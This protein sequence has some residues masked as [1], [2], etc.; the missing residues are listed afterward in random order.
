MFLLVYMTQIIKLTYFV[1]K[2]NNK[3]NSEN[4]NL[5]N[6]SKS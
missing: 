1:S 4:K 6:A 3:E 2:I 5:L